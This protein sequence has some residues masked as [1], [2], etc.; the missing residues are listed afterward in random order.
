MDYQFGF[1]VSE[2]WF[3]KFLERALVWLVLLQIFILMLSTGFVIINPN[4]LA[5]VERFGK[6]RAVDPVLEPGL[7]F[8]L[9]WPIEQIY[10]HPAKE[11]QNFSVGNYY[12]DNASSNRILLWQATQGETE[13][14]FLVASK[15]QTSVEEDQTVPVNLLTAAV[16]IQ[17]VVNDFLAWSYKHAE[18]AK[19]LK[20]I[21]NREVVRYLVSVDIIDFMSTGRLEAANK[22]KE[23][24]Q[25][26]ANSLE[27]GVEVLFVGL[28]D[29]HPPIG[30]KTTPVAASF[31]EVIGA[32]ED[33]ANV[34]KAVAYAEMFLEAE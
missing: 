34:L 24:I 15:E 28:Q 14:N 29:I 7:H 26:Q 18:P 11:I 12:D 10:R 1:K 8:K 31:E 20:S 5:I 22:L 21:S 30:D 33:G 23:N 17:Y 32:G 6:P 3:Y 2:T 27:L 4:E 19:L 25:Y 9:P 16:P 13:T